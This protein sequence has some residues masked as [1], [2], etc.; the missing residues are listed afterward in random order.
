MSIPEVTIREETEADEFATE[1]A[2]KKAFWNLHHPGCDEHYLVHR[3]RGDPSYVP[4]LTRVAV[5][6][7]EI[8]GAILYARARVETADGDREVLTF[9]PLCVVPE[10]QNCGIGGA[11]LEETMELA[12]GMG[13]KTIIIFGEPGYYPRHGFCTCDRFGITTAEGKNFDAFMGIELI[14]GG[15]DGIKGRFFDPPVYENL[16]EALVEEYDK[17]FPYMPKLKLPGQWS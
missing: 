11:L 2:V 10:Y 15:F 17:K 13:F 14:P 3:L 6:D 8:V 7:G 1:L 5:V 9:G 16:P 4:Q 12:R